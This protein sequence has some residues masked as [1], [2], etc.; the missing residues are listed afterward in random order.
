MLL[1]GNGWRAVSGFQY[2][3]VSN[4]ARDPGN[5]VLDTR[6]MIPMKQWKIIVSI[7]GIL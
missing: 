1:S 6:M 7:T 4:K 2:V 5:R 3:K